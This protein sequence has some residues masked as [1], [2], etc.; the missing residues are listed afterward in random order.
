G[1]LSAPQ[2]DRLRAD[3]RGAPDLPAAQPPAGADPAGRGRRGG[4]HLRPVAGHAVRVRPQRRLPVHRDDRVAAV[5]GRQLCPR[6]RRDRCD[7]RP[8]DDADHAAGRRL[9][10][11]R[12]RDPPPRI[13]R[14]AAA[15][16]DRHPRRLRLAGPVRL[17]HLLGDHADPDRP[18]DRDLG[19][20]PTGL[21]VAEVLP[22]HAV[23]LAADA[24]RDRRDVPVV[25]QRDRHPDPEHPR[26]PE[27]D[28]RDDLPELGLRRVLHRLRGQGA[29]LAVPHLAGRRL[30]GRADRLGRDALRGDVEDGRLRPDPL[31]PAAVRTGLG[32]VGAGGDRPLDRRHPLRRPR[33]AGPDGHEAAARLLVAQPHGVRDAGPV[34]LQHAGLPGL[35][36]RDGRPR[37]QLGRAVP[38]RRCARPAGR[39]DRDPRLQWGRLAA[40]GLRRLFH[41]VHVRQHR[42]TRSFG[43]HRRIPRRARDVGLQPVGGDLHLR[44]RRLLRL[45]HALDVPA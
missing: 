14:L 12:R 45:V 11:G 37:D 32:V 15:A 42:A 43:V 26:A 40:A 6:R 30:P 9:V 8:V 10:L 44:G 35:A 1:Q 7:P 17:L 20:L 5:A 31:Q 18:P 27:R 4:G 33:R 41:P 38:A 24:G 3:H 16:G 25:L 23:Q 13:L 39:H 36:A 28:L 29:D 21:R 22:L 2:P 34:R 19:R